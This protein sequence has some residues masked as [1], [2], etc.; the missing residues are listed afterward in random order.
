M[1]AVQPTGYRN[2]RFLK[3]MEGGEQFQKFQSAD[4][5]FLTIKR[6][7]SCFKL[8]NSIEKEGEQC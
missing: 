3:Y 1:G 7:D 4:E 6:S 8:T 2:A 5:F